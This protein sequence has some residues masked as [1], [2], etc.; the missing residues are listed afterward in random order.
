MVQ[1]VM[2]AQILQDVDRLWRGHIAVC[3]CP[4]GRH[5]LPLSVRTASSRSN[6]PIRSRA[7]RTVTSG[8]DRTNFVMI[9]AFWVNVFGRPTPGLPHTLVQTRPFVSVPDVHDSI[10]LTNVFSLP[11]RPSMKC[12]SFAR[13]DRPRSTAQISF[14]ASC[15]T[16]VTCIGTRAEATRP[17]STRITSVQRFVELPIFASN[18][19]ADGM[20]SSKKV[21]RCVL[22][23]AQGYPVM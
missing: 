19:C 6:D 7:S 16:A 18:T 5:S 10:S 9:L 8:P 15:A 22:M 3:L 1:R 2:Q 20:I 12:V 23:Q 11:A 4:K 13:P 17:S 21:T 14:A